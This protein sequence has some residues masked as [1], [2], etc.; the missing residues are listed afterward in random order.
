MELTEKEKIVMKA[1]EEIARDYGGEAW[2]SLI[3]SYAEG[4]IKGKSIS[5][6]CSSLVK[7]GLIASDGADFN[8]STITILESEKI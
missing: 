4:A 2:G 7:K 1:I 5:G 8:D 3:E 6:V